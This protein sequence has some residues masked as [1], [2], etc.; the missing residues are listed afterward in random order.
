MQRRSHDTTDVYKLAMGG[1]AVGIDPDPQVM[2]IEEN[3]RSR[4]G[5]GHVL[6][7]RLTRFVATCCDGE[8]YN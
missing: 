3:R 1:S 6:S 4:T 8:Y 5:Y 7:P 2:E